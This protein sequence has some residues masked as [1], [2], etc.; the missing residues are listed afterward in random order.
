MVKLIAV[1]SKP[2]DPAAFDKR[3]QEHLVV[4][5][6]M[7]GVTDIRVSKATGAPR[8]EPPHYQ[9]SEVLFPDAATMQA[10]LSSPEGITAFKDVMSFAKGQVAMFFAEEL[11]GTR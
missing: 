2:Q 7:P 8:G 9:I 10:S 5:R 6:K 3:Y 1:F 11:G 4:A